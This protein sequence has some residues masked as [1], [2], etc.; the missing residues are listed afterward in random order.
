MF[1]VDAFADR[2]FEGNAAAVCPLERWLDERTLQAIAEENNLSETAFFVPIDDRFEL[3]WFTPVAEV[4]LCG[5]ATLASAH[6]LFHHLDFAGTEASFATRSGTLAVRKSGDGYLM[7]LPLDR[8]AKVEAPQALSA[9]LQSRPKEVLA[10]SDYIAVYEFAEEVRSLAPEL[11][12][13]HDLDRRGVVVTAP[14]GDAGFVCRCFFPKLGV[15]ED[16]VTGSAFCQ[17]APYWADRL[18]R[19]DLKARQLSRRGGA[20]TCAVGGDHVTL[21]GNAITYMFAEIDVPC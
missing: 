7:D 1:Q 12:E 19:N 16:P 13:F 2:V 4:D 17:I 14:E 8:P 20:A 10:A 18:G 3:R 5:H 9:G 11:C 15:P 6:V 21:G